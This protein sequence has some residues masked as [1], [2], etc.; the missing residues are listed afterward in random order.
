[1]NLIQPIKVF[2]SFV[3]LILVVM[4]TSETSIIESTKTV[5][6]VKVAKTVDPKQLKC[7]AMNIKHHNILQEYISLKLL[8]GC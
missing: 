2:T 5:E 7:L 6:E 8:T 3:F 4:F 1:M